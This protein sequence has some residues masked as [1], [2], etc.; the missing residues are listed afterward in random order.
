MNADPRINSILAWHYRWL[1][2]EA[3]AYASAL[4]DPSQRRIF[5]EIAERYLR[6]AAVDAGSAQVASK[7]AA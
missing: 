6:L 7:S 1:A 2:E 4:N 5:E 3:Q